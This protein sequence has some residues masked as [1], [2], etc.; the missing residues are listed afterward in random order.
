MTAYSAIANSEIA[1]GAPLTNSLMTKVRDNP[2]AIQEN[3]ATAP[4]V[5]YA[6]TAGTVTGPGASMVLISTAT[7]SA[8]ATIDFTGIDNTYKR[9]IYYYTGAIPATDSS[10]L[11]LRTSTDGGTSFDSGATDY[12]Y[13][14]DGNASDGVPSTSS[15]QAAQIA[16]TPEPIGSSATGEGC[17]GMIIIHNPSISSGATFIS[18]NGCYADPTANAGFSVV[19]GMRDTAADVDAIRFLFDTGNIASGEFALYGLKDS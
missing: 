17:S 10:Y 6:T 13:A 14:C 7:A 11:Y 8:S 18:G 9:Y 16:L 19:G 12:R 5:A 3:D 2:L 15:G 4:E 1:V